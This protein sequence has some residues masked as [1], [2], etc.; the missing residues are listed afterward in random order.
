MAKMLL[1][2]PRFSSILPPAVK[3]ETTQFRNSDKESRSE[4]KWFPLFPKL[5]LFP[6]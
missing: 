5:S 1:S 4:L 3:R 6:F 2:S